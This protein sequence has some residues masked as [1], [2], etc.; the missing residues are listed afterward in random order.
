MVFLHS[1][2]L[3]EAIIAFTFTVETGAVVAGSNSFVTVVEADDYLIAN[4]HVFAIWNAL[5]TTNK[6]YLLAW[7]SRYLDQ[8]ANWEG[9]KTA[10]TSSMR[11]PRTGVHDRDGIPVGINTIPPQLKA[12]T[13][14]MARYLITTDRSDDRGQDGLESL[15]VD[16]IEL[17]FNPSYRLPEVPSEIQDLIRGIGYI[18]S[19]SGGAVKILRA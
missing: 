8:R 12:A 10:D 16:V 3:W 18:S 14:E 19:G 11:W 15:K 13:I 1:I 4:I 6:Q 5:T 2:F 17:V 9:T 7:G